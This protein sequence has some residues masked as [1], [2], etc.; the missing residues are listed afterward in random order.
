M[1]LYMTDRNGKVT[2]DT[3][4]VV[5]ELGEV[6]SVTFKGVPIPRGEEAPDEATHQVLPKLDLRKDVRT[7]RPADGTWRGKGKELGNILEVTFTVEGNG[8]KLK[9]LIVTTKTRPISGGAY[10]GPCKATFQETYEVKDGTLLVKP[11]QNET[12]AIYFVSPTNAEGEAAIHTSLPQSRL[13]EE[14]TEFTDRG[15]WTATLVPGARDSS[16]SEQKQ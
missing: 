7:F 2:S 3:I 9:D 5:Y 8:T 13:V 10:V 16:R 11:G 12:V 4:D 1:S 15:E 6:K 14:P